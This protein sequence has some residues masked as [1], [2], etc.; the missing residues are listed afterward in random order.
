MCDVLSPSLT[1]YL[2]GLYYHRAVNTI[3]EYHRRPNRCSHSEIMESH[4]SRVNIAV[5]LR[6]CEDRRLVGG[7]KFKA[8]SIRRSTGNDYHRG[9]SP[10]IYE[11]FQAFST[12]IEK[13][14]P[15]TIIDVRIIYIITEVLS[16]RIIIDVRINYIITEVLS[17]S[18][19]IDVR[20]IYIIID[21]I[22]ED[23]HRRL[24]IFVWKTPTPTRGRAVDA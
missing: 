12:I 14:S 5:C 23:Y 9:L 7:G 2:K 17:S 3:T 19:I 11:L 16:S 10:S 6:F 8:E 1:N 24:R 22:T 20:I 4:A 21:T 15:R 18:I 13:L